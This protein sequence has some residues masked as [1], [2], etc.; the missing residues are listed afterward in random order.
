MASSTLWVRD[1]QPQGID[2]VLK[3]LQNP[4]SGQLS[5][6]SV[7]TAIAISFGVS[8]GIALIFSFIRPYNQNVYAPKLKHSDEKHAPLPIGNKPWSW[9]TVLLGIPEEQLIP[10]IGMDATIF[11]RFVRMCRN[12]FLI[13]AALGLAIIVPINV[14]MQLYNPPSNSKR[15]ATTYDPQSKDNVWL[16]KMTPISVKGSAIWAQVVFAY[17]TNFIVAGFLWWNYRKVMQLRRRYFDSDDYQNSLHARTL[18]LYDLPRESS[19]DEGIARIIDGVVPNSSFARTAI[20]RNVKDLPELNEQHDHAVRKLEKILAKYLKNPQQLPPSRPQCKPS[21]KDRAYSTY[22]SGQKVDS[23]DYYTKRIK[24]LEN[25]IKT[26]RASV[27]RRSTMPYG[28]AS[29][30][31]IS[32]AHSIAYACRKKKPQGATI[33]LAPQPSNIIWKNMTLSSSLRS[34]RRFANSL[35]VTFLTLLW[36]VPNALIAVFLV[37]LGNLGSVWPGFNTTLKAHTTFWGIVQGIAAPTLTSLI[38]LVLPMIFRRL[39]TKGG[40]QTKTSRDRHVIAKLFAF[41]VFNNLV[42]FS[43]FSV[44]W[45]IVAGIKA[46]TD[47]GEGVWNSIVDANIAHAIFFALCKNSTFWVTYLLQRQLG[48]TID[49][50]QLWPLIQAWFL[51]KF[52]SPTPRE[53]IEM[54]AP[55]PFDYSGYY[56][57]FLFY[58]TISLCFAGIQPLVLVATAAYF[59]F[60]VY[61]KRYLLLYRFVTKNESGG[62]TWRTLFNRVIFAMLLANAVYLLVTWAGLITDQTHAHDLAIHTQFWAIIPLFFFVI[63]FKIYCSRT[64]DDKIRYYSLR[65]T[66]KMAEEATQK[67]LRSDRLASKFGHPALY[68]KLITPMVDQ[69]AQN[70]LPSVYSGRLTDGREGDGG[71]MMTISGYSDSYAMDM[72]S[73]K[74]GKKSAVPGFEFVDES[75]M[76]FEYFKNRAEFNEDFGGSDL[77][78]HDP[79]ITRPTTPGSMTDLGYGSRPGTPGSGRST[80]YNGA[81]QHRRGA[82]GTSDLSYGAY[83]PDTAATGTAAHQRMGSYPDRVGTASPF[84]AQ[85]NTSGSA[86][87]NNAGNSGRNSPAPIRRKSPGPNQMATGRVS[88][89]P[90]NMSRNMSPGPSALGRQTSPGPNNMGRQTSPGPNNMGRQASPGPNSMSRNTSPGPN[91]MGAQPA[92]PTIGALGG[93]P[94]GYSGLPQIETD[95]SLFGQQGMHHAGPS[96]QYNMSATIQPYTSYEQYSVPQSAASGVYNVQG[97]NQ[98]LDHEHYQDHASPQAY[99]P[100]AHNQQSPGQHG[101]GQQ[102]QQYDYF[103]GGNG[104]KPGEG[105]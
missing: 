89:G 52:S 17:L 72:M 67:Q 41:F 96:D 25:E 49:L 36:I 53:I 3:L 98:A 65:K 82:T 78:G 103:R 42:V 35:W 5:S 16:L 22:P 32:E 8:A 9:V 80:P 24:D 34:R 92:G 75:H 101:S 7:F 47:K 18:M 46:S 39:A 94:S 83:R 79:N 66:G 93:G 54:T 23:I 97:F 59:S 6:A 55:P 30:S 33:S 48:A 64:F 91:N 57:Y 56:T 45:S 20:A 37:D 2:E 13:L 12:M 74:V 11:L 68:K 95:T 60:D 28:F 69:K 84:Y 40:D 21:K 4:F 73:G 77:Y 61:L 105:W 87:M 15:D 38:Y 102:Q 31:E 51:R 14:T 99:D 44:V 86:L 1:E 88:P 62:V 29:Y 85:D 90:N 10:Q 104:R 26:V 50:A 58:T 100:L 76:D 43:L 27:D 81:A 19:S 70:L 63:G 71:D